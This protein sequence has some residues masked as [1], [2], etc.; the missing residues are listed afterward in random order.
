MPDLYIIGGPNGAGK[1]TTAIRVFPR[2]G[3]SAFVN[4]DIIAQGLSPLDV[5]SAARDAGRLML[6]EMERYLERGDDFALETTLASRSLA[7]FVKRCQAAGY[8]F[9]LIYVWLRDADLAVERVAKRVAAGGH[10]IPEDVIR[11]RYERGRANFFGL[12][13]ELADEW[14]VIDNSGPISV[15]V[16]RSREG[17]IEILQPETWELIS[18]GE[19]L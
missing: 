6:A 8:R 15:Y 11:R 12:Y 4:A 5:E 14:S 13:R 17:D 18:Q 7:G 19:D 1:T 9:H 2:L 10:N 3:V 16:A